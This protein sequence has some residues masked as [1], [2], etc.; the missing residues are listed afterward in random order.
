MPGFGVGAQVVVRDVSAGDPSPWPD[1]PSGVIVGS[2]GSAIAGVWGRAVRGRVW[3][4]EF[5]E[6]QRHS[7]GSGPFPGA[8]VHE[9][10]LELAPLAD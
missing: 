9:R 2:S 1:S 10:Y 6:P 4:V 8:P 7:D 3:V 5:D